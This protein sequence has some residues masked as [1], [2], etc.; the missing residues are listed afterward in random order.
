MMSETRNGALLG[1]MTC[2][3]ATAACAVEE[4]QPAWLVDDDE[5]AATAPGLDAPHVPLTSTTGGQRLVPGFAMEIAKAG[6]HIDLD[7]ADQ[8]PGASYEVWVSDDPYFAPE[9]DGSVM[10]ASGL[11]AP[12]YQY[13]MGNDG[14]ERYYRVRASGGNADLS[15][16]VGQLSYDVFPGFTKLGM[17]LVSDVDTS[18]EL[19][20]D[21]ESWATGTYMW[22]ASGQQWDWP[23]NGDPPGLSFGVGEVVSVHHHEGQPL[24]ADTY[25]TVGL[26]PTHEDVD[27]PLYPGDNLVTLMPLRFGT[28]M[29]SEVL[30]AVEHGVRV[31]VWDAATQT[32]TWYPDDGDFQIPT[33]SPL[34]IEVDAL[35]TWPPPPPTGCQAPDGSTHTESEFGQ[36]STTT[37]YGTPPNAA[38]FD[39]AGDNVWRVHHTAHQTSSFHTDGVTYDPAASGPIDTIDFS[40][41]WTCESCYGLGQGW[42][43]AIRQDGVVYI[44]HA[45][46]GYYVTGSSA[47]GSR[48]VSGLNEA[49]WGRYLNRF[50]ADY[51]DAP[52]FS[53]NGS[54]LE[55]GL[56]TW[57]NGGAGITMLYDNV[58]FAFNTTCE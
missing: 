48:S 35:S 56:A 2:A 57:Q 30:E 40:V 58:N 7:W 29:A 14:L 19:L 31:G 15:T 6:A 47:T 54:P 20:D 36:W 5:A 49:R 3:L 44:G 12:S 26:V 24:A 37:V 38:Q 1:L 10:V 23:A 51:S 41:D 28:S 43:P 4:S 55:L 42:Y 9:D 32:E 53:E 22:D 39:D 50:S 46:G 27:I 13:A 18:A 8:G 16:T 25:T 45:S 21:L 52:D 17:C 34:H 33:C 11:T